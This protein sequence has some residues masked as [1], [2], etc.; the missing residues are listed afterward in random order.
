MYGMLHFWCDLIS[1]PLILILNTLSESRMFDVYFGL[2]N[3]V[4][5]GKKS[6]SLSSFI[7]AACPKEE[8][9]NAHIIAGSYL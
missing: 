2:R 9:N 1:P 7:L 4:S 3:T 5:V 6:N 8:C